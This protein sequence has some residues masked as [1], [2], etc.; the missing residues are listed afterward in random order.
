[1]TPTEEYVADQL[2]CL[3]ELINAL[4]PYSPTYETDKA[5]HEAAIDLILEG[6]PT[7]NVHEW[8]TP[9]SAAFPPPM[10]EEAE[11][12]GDVNA[13]V[14][15]DTS[16]TDSDTVIFTSPSLHGDEKSI[17]DDDARAPHGTFVPKPIMFGQLESRFASLKT[18]ASEHTLADT[19]GESLPL[20]GRPSGTQKS[21]AQ[22]EA[23]ST[24]I[25]TYEQALLFLGLYAG[26]S[27]EFV[28]TMYGIK[29]SSPLLAGV[30]LVISNR[31]EMS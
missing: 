7:D 11:D 26:Q 24:V 19:D 14:R 31:A 25:E 30:E 6:V 16:D 28:E 21:T 1:M 9:G 27:D 12:E 13:N 17:C 18:D 8:S 5:R 10:A 29:V 20:Q 4:N 2:D 23:A 3:Y 15:T 22:P